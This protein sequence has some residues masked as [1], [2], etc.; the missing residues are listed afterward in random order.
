MNSELF[1]LRKSGGPGSGRRGPG[2]RWLAHRST[3]SI[4]GEL[5]I[6]QSAV[7]I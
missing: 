7:T 6:R 1:F 4:K 2:V 3:R 5:F